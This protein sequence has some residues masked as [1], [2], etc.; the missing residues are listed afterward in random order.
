[1]ELRRY[2]GN[3]VDDDESGGGQSTHVDTLTVQP[4][5]SGI[6]MYLPSGQL[7]V[8]ARITHEPPPPTAA[9]IKT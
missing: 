1:M 2:R 9:D 5:K 4:L 7:T 3:V 8:L 6:G